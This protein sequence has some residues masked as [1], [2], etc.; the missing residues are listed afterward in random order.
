LGRTKLYQELKFV[1][2]WEYFFPG[3][4]REREMERDTERK[5]TDKTC[6]GKGFGVAMFP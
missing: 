5:R 6:S 1:S 4:G 2:N 3:F